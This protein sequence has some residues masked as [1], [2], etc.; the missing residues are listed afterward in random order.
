M[1]GVSPKSKEK[2]FSEKTPS[3]KDPV[4]NQITESEPY[5]KAFGDDSDPLPENLNKALITLLKPH[6]AASEQF[7]LLKNN[8]LFPEK[9]EPPRTIM[10][11]SASPSDGKS[12][13][14]ANLAI[15]MANS[16]DEFVLLV[17]GD[18]R[19]PS[20]HTLFGFKKIEGL[21]EY[22]SSA[23][24]LS[25]VL[26]KT[27][28]NKLTILPGG[29]IPQNPS[30]LLSSEQMRRLLHE[31]KLRYSDRYI[32]IDTP[33]PYLTSETSAIARHVD[34]IIIVIK[35]GKTRKKEVQDIMDI[36]G[37]E[38]ILGVVQNHSK[39]TIGY[40]YGY[41]KFGYGKH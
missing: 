25:R 23:M 13:V 19:A 22:L 2:D 4:N 1:H 12:F 29:S 11:T 18:L 30:E 21:S 8:I 36:Y 17:D 37:K 9:G 39:K 15:S 14:A 34:G 28:V 3:D 35:Q 10:I 20:I 5:D 31:V 26:K 7:R 33:P 41:H 38:K 16:I 32:L 27:F 24:P 6:S 40:G